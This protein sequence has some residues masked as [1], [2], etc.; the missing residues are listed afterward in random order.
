MSVPSRLARPILLA[1]MTLVAM[2][3][4]KGGSSLVGSG[5]GDGVGAQAGGAAVGGQHQRPRRSHADADHV[6]LEGEHGVVA[7]HA[8]VTASPHADHAHA[9]LPRL[10]DGDVH[11]L[12]GEDEAQALVAVDGGGGGALPHD[13]PLGRGVRAAVAVGGDV[14]AKLV[15][16]AVAVDA[17]E[18]GGDED[19]GGEGRVVAGD[20]HG[21][22]D[23]LDRGLQGVRCDSD[24]VA[25]SD[26][27]LL[28]HSAPPVQSVYAAL[29]P[30]LSHPSTRSG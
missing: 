20:A 5:E 22:E 2:S 15:R 6:V 21:G 7:G 28:K 1:A 9:D 23:R 10:G 27:E 3:R 8:E 24:G 16:D 13:A 17:A 25:F 30:A 4:T 12:G 11:G 29:T 18:V 19:V 14:G 26:L